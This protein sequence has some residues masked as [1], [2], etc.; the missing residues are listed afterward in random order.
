[1]IKNKMLRIWCLTFPWK[2]MSWGLHQKRN[3]T[4]AQLLFLSVT[5]EGSVVPGN[6]LEIRS[7]LLEYCMN[8]HEHKTHTHLLKLQHCL[9]LL[10]GQGQRLTRRLEVWFSY[11]GLG[12]EEPWILSP[13]LC[14]IRVVMP[15]CDQSSGE[16]K[17]EDHLP[18]LYIAWG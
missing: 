1:M 10:H 11:K 6:M 5:L 7:I 9:C 15:A 18:L 13:A 3:R 14:E 17:A 4:H 16:V 8:T 12:C 2:R